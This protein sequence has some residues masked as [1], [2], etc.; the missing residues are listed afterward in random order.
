MVMKEVTLLISFV[1]TTMVAAS[2]MLYVSPTGSDEYDG[3]TP[4]TAV[5]TLTRATSLL[6]PNDRIIVQSASYF[7]ETS[8]V[9]NVRGTSWFSRGGQV[10]ISGGKRINEWTESS[11]P[12]T[13]SSL[14]VYQAD[15]T[16]FNLSAATRHLFVNGR[17]AARARLSSSDTSA[18]FL[19]SNITSSGYSLNS[20]TA[21]HGLLRPQSELVFSQNTSPWTEPRCAVAKVTKDAITMMQP[22]WNNLIHKA[23]GQNAKGPPTYLEGLDESFISSPGEW[24][25]STDLNTVYYSPLASEQQNKNL[26]AVIPVL[27]VLVDIVSGGD[28]TSFTGF[29]FEHATWLRPGQEDGYVEQQT[30][31]CALGQNKGNNNCDTD[32][33]WS[34]KSP[35]N[36]RVSNVTGVSFRRCEFTRL[37]GTGLDVTYGSNTLVDSCFFHDISGNGVQ[38]GQFQHPEAS[39]LDVGAVVTN[40]II[41]KAGAEYSGA[42]GISIGYT[43][44][45][46]LSHND[47]SNLSYVP[48]TVGWGWERHECWNCTNAGNNTIIG[49]RCYD[50][51]QTLNDGGGIYMLGPQNGSTITRNWVHDQGTSSSGALYPDQGSAYSEWTENVVTNIGASE[52][53]HLWQA[54]IHDLIVVNNYADTFRN[55]S[56][57]TNCTV[58]DNTFFTTGVPPIEATQIMQSSGVNR[59]NPW[60]DTLSVVVYM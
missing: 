34:N 18:L 58:K 38:I 21:A 39:D 47:V 44:N 30:G 32:F 42:A 56:R 54:S 9:I 13:N 28:D 45:L 46:T 35:G 23:C 20:S 27:E 57:G 37:G 22:C 16:S 41:N 50:Y 36:I 59:S 5:Q 8:L 12:V 33:W 53:L 19:H 24:A 4:S 26:S 3:R 29:T 25:L 43:Q 11:S 49:N 48:I 17:R 15:V 7:L 2:S 6:K 55:E 31:Q 14:V 52:W 1:M 40:T 51:K 60:Y 10:S